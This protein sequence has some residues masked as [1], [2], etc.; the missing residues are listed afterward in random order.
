MT[1]QEILNL[2]FYRRYP[3]AIKTPKDYVPVWRE[4]TETDIIKHLQGIHTIGAYQSCE[5]ETC[6]WA[7]IDFDD[8]K[9]KTDAENIIEDIKNY[10]NISSM[11]VGIS[12][13]DCKLEK[14][15]RGY[16][17][18]IFF[19]TPKTTSYAY[20][21]IIYFLKQRKLSHGLKNKIDIFPRKPTLSGK[22]LGGL[23]RIP[24]TFKEI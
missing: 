11:S 12:I 15:N 20:K 21:C 6:T 18:W 22:R 3:F 19:A 1:P 5:D 9:Y 2:F 10:I 16:H 4:V 24:T 17:V 13:K 23:V 7:C 14:T 8:F